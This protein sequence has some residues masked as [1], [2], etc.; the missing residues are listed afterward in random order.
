MAVPFCFYPL[1]STLLPKP[2]ARKP[3]APFALTF[4]DDQPSPRSKAAR[5]KLKYLQSLQCTSKHENKARKAGAMVIAGVDEAG[6]GCLFGPVV[7]AAVILD[8]AY[9]VR[10]LRDSK[11]TTEEQREALALR[12]RMHSLG[13]AWAA[14]D[15]DVIDEINIL[16]ASRLAMKLA[17]EKLA[18]LGFS[19]D[20]LLVDY[21]V[22]DYPSKESRM[23]QSNLVHG[24]AVCASIA[25]ASILAKVERDQLMR[26][27]ARQFPH[28]DLASNKGY[29]SPK[30]LRAL[31]E[32]GVT[33][34]H[35]K[36]FA[37]VREA[38]GQQTKLDFQGTQI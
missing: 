16:E 6:R 3:P 38:L 31:R 25:A 28:Y 14:V 27:L 37:P 35:R 17:L 34:L 9:R 11:L 26:D 24:D 15:S 36:S 22:V 20:Y 7:A 13:Y 30:H 5:D 10:G 23:V 18:A 19:L 21:I 29:A 1:R 32:H 8:P 33:Q 2:M 12:V 4:D